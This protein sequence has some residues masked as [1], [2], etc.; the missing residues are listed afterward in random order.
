MTKLNYSING[1]GDL[2]LCLLVILDYYNFGVLVF[3][4]LYVLS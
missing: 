2:E 4:V 3:R 1:L